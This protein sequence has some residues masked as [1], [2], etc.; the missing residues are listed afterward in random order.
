MTAVKDIR[1]SVIEDSADF[2]RALEMMINGT[3][4][5]DCLSSFTDGETACL[6]IPHN[7]PDVVLVDIGLPGMNGIECIRR[8]AADVPRLQFLVLTIKDQED[9]IFGALQAG[10]SG[11]LLKI[12][13]PFEILKGIRELY[14]GGA[15]MSA[16]IARK[17]VRHFRKSES[18]ANPFDEILTAREQEILQLLSRGKFYKEIAAELGISIETVKSHCHNI[19]KKLHVA[20]RTEALNKYFNR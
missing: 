18:E 16:N 19:Y 17:V 7:P 5:L 13:S 9:E 2:N 10:A 11:Y 15:P 8:L 14:D 1:I 6:E 3:E 4:G 12:S 20:S